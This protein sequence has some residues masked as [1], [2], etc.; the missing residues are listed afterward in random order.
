VLAKV[1]YRLLSC[2]CTGAIAWTQFIEQANCWRMTLAEADGNTFGAQRTDCPY[3]PAFYCHLRGDRA[4]ASAQRPDHA[5]RQRGRFRQTRNGVSGAQFLYIDALAATGGRDEE[6]ALFTDLLERRNSFGLL[7]GRPPGDR[8][9]NLPQ[10]YSV[11]GI[12]N[13]TMRPS[14]K[15]ED[16]WCRASS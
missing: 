12:I 10:T 15:W 9:A 11:A 4:R 13:L 2:G 1:A 7:L 6:R 16:A 3:R 8:G 5:R 14:D